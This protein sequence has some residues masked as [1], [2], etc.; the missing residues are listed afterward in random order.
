MSLLLIL[1]ISLN[2]K[3]VSE[4]EIR[5][6]GFNT[7]FLPTI[8]IDSHKPNNSYESYKAV[9]YQNT[10]YDLQST[11]C[12]IKNSSAITYTWL[13]HVATPSYSILFLSSLMLLI[14]S[15]SV[16]T[17]PTKHL[18]ITYF[19]ERNLTVTIQVHLFSFFQYAPCLT[20][21]ATSTINSI[22]LFYVILGYSN[23]WW[24]RTI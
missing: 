15:C 12:S 11:K 19:K 23:L 13:K 10:A 3:K 1:I 17:G 21:L 5:N 6:S 20:V 22:Y 24:R 16:S 8:K 18:F 9:F 2:I 4:K 7:D 14:I